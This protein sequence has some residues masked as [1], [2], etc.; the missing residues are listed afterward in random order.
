M[1]FGDMIRQAWELSGL[2]QKQFGER[3]GVQQP[4]VVEIFASESITEALLDRCVLALGAQLE[5]RIVQ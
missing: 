4:R 1:P 5:V 2:T 3:I